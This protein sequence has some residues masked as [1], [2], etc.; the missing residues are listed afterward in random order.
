MPSRAFQRGGKQMP[1]NKES[2]FKEAM[3]SFETCAGIDLMEI[4]QNALQVRSW[5]GFGMLSVDYE[6]VVS[7][8]RID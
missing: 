5:Y 1:S 4:I 7:G 6:A 2:D 8:R 3:N